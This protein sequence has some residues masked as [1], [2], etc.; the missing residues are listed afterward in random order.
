MKIK[1]YII[2]SLFLL[3]GLFTSCNNDRNS[4]APVGTLCLGVDKNEQLLTKGEVV[5]ELLKVCIISAD[6][7]TVKS[8]EDYI[9]E[10]KNEKLI[11]PVGTYKVAVASNQTEEPG[12]EKPFYAGEETVDVKAGEITSATVTCKIANT[13]VTIGYTDKV[14][15]KFTNCE[16][17]VSNSSGSLLYT[18]DEYRSGFFVPEKLTVSLALTNNEGKKYAIK[19]VFSDIKPRYHYTIMFNMADPSDDKEGGSDF[20]VEVNDEIQ[21]VECEIVIDEDDMEDKKVPVIK[22]SDSF[23][24]NQFSIKVGE[25]LSPLSLS[26]TS[27]VGIETLMVKAESELFK[28]AN[29]LNEFDLARLEEITKMHLEELGFP[30]L[31]D[32]QDA[33]NI[34]LSFDQLVAKFLQ[35]IANEKAKKVHSFIV[36]AMDSLHQETEV[37]FAFEVR[38]DVAVVTNKANAFSTFAFLS[39]ETQETSGQAFKFRKQGDSDF[40]TIEAQVNADGTFS[41]LVSELTPG[42]DYEYMAVTGDDSEGDLVTFQTEGAVELPGGKFDEWD[43]NTPKASV[44][45]FWKS[46]NNTFTSSLLSPTSEVVDASND[47][48]RAANLQ[49]TSA[50]GKFAAGNLFTGDFKLD[51]MTGEITFGRSFTSRPSRLKVWYKYA[52]GTIDYSGTITTPSK[53]TINVTGVDTCSVYIALVK[54]RFTIR[55]DNTNSFF[56][57]SSTWFKENVI[58]YAALPAEQCITTNNVYKEFEL[59]LK[60]FQPEYTGNFYIAIVCSS[61]KYGDYF[62]GSTKSNLKLDEFELSY[63]YDPN[64]F[65]NE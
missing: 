33:K 41:A 39:G 1:E 16:A 34:T 30:L 26:I 52:P 48:K 12:W 4:L 50:A 55:T 46:G 15:E 18:Y 51:V 63:D 29:G 2:Y 32:D 31:P 17:T 20:T 57:L 25:E 49:S 53:V 7:D 38:P 10:V 6:G 56:D 43:G 3:A 11:L 54:D 21:V 24:E 28:Q 13:K 44:S 5:G 65:S 45:P 27:Q 59:T 37:E 42:T 8:Y 47:S 19:R 35:D 61:S 60:Y 9:K 14:K 36:Y 64:C 40:R 62:K 58:A 23:K 22:L